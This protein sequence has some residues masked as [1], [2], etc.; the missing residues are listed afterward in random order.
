MRPVAYDEP[1]HSIFFGGFAD[2]E[3]YR[4]DIAS[5]MT[6]TSI[7]LHPEGY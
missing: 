2:D 5:G 1:T 4:Y 3:V 6:D 7:A